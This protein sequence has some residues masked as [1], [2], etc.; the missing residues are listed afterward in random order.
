[1]FKGF[2]FSVFCF[3]I[4]VLVFGFFGFEFL[5][6]GYWYWVLVFRLLVSGF[7]FR[8]WCSEVRT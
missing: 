8:V 7:G 5:V 2:R 3:G 1:M 6:L 4:W